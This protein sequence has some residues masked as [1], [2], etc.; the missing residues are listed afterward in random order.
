MPSTTATKQKSDFF[1]GTPD[2]DPLPSHFITASS[3][4]TDGLLLALKSK[5]CG[6]GVAFCTGERAY[7]TLPEFNIH[8][9]QNCF[10]L[11]IFEVPCPKQSQCTKREKKTQK[12]KP[13][14]FAILDQLSRQSLPLSSLTQKR[15]NGRKRKTVK[16][17]NRQNL[18]RDWLSG[19][20]R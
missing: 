20:I 3:D 11:G 16:H 8:Q 12:Q 14:G 15:P 1:T 2:A 19:R 9:R 10:T 4:M 6:G 18:M 13:L 17:G 5:V 7:S